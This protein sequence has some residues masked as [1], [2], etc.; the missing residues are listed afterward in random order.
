MTICL[1]LILAIC[2][3]RKSMIVHDTESPYWDQGS[4]KQYKTQNSKFLILMLDTSLALVQNDLIL[5]T[6]AKM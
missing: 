3:H 2:K 6:K 1:I 5:Q 4:F